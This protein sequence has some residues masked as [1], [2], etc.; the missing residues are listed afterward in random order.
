VGIFDRSSDGGGVVS[1][2]VNG[3][4]NALLPSQ[5]GNSGKVLT[6]DGTTTSWQTGGGGGEANTA[7]NVGTGTGQVFKQKTGVDLELKT[8]KS[9]TNTT[10]TN[11]ASDITIEANGTFKHDDGTGSAPSITFATDVSTGFFKS[12]AQ[13]ISL[14]TGSASNVVWQWQSTFA[15][16]FKSYALRFYDLTTN[17]IALKAP[18]SVTS[19]DLTLP[20]AQG[21]SGQTLQ[22]DGSGNL[23]WV[24][25]SGGGSSFSDSSFEIY[26]NVDNTKKLKTE[27]TNLPGGQTITFDF[28]G[29]S[30]PNSYRFPALNNSQPSQTQVL[31]HN[32]S[33]SVSRKTFI[34]DPDLGTPN[35][36]NDAPYFLN[37]SS[38]PAPESAYN[39][40]YYENFAP[41]FRKG[42]NQGKNFYEQ[43]HL[44][45][46]TVAT[47]NVS[48]TGEQ[49]INGVSTSASRVLLTAQ[50]A[51]AENG[52]WITGAGAWE[53]PGQGGDA[54]NDNADGGLSAD[55]Y[56][57]LVI[58]VNQ[59]TYAN[60]FWTM[61]TTGDFTLGVTAQTWV[62]FIQGGTFKSNSSGINN[63]TVNYTDT[64]KTLNIPAGTVANDRFL[65]AIAPDANVQNKSFQ[66]DENKVQ[67]WRFLDGYTPASGGGYSGLGFSNSIPQ[68]KRGG[69]ADSYNPVYLQY[70]VDAARA[71]TTTNIASLTGLLTVDG[72]TLVSGD[73]VLV[74]D[75]TTATQNGVYIAQSGS[76][77]RAGDLSITGDFYTGLRVYVNEGTTQV[78]TEWEVTSTGTITVGSSSINFKTS[79][80]IYYDSAA[81][82]GGSATET[83]TITG[84]A[85]ADTILSVSQK[86][87]GAN[88]TAIIGWANQ[89]ANS[90]DLTWT[91]DPG[92]GAIVRVAVR[93]G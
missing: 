13:A 89:A 46:A 1:T 74:K 30:K 10:V 42:S 32:S 58:Y 79:S 62:Q 84:L 38:P 52:L 23:S 44:A 55:Y 6:T 68:I 56:A 85:A 75:Q 21:S 88:S 45:V 41:K 78:N 60:T 3:D 19:Y 48:L 76:W 34:N 51:P 61:T 90:L 49:S 43:R 50:T 28:E 87:P 29:G 2:P 53:R 14:V 35:K 37:V 22:N 77:I 47:S 12:G 81:S 63:L 7:S 59:G 26:D 31:T 5:T 92:A 82:A 57:G 83:L 27:L 70:R 80:V 4:I 16:I 17:Y 66:G 73:R 64:A 65:F 54:G 91:G 67:N 18:N 93:K 33:A 25:P 72:V 71:A 8:L 36:F 20:S 40:H 9:G 39:A 86:T 69:L 11:N 24:T 15:A